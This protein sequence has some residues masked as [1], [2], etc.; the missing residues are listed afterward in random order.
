M[1]LSKTFSI[2]VTASFFLSQPVLAQVVISEIMYDLKGSD[3]LN[4]K[5]REW[6]E[7]ANV[8]GSAVAVATTTW[9]F[10]DSV[11]SANH[12]LSLYQGT[13]TILPGGFA[14][15]A[16]DPQTFLAD[17]PGFA[18]TIFGSSFSLVNSSATITLK[19]NA[20][21]VVDQVTYASTTGAAGDGNSLGL[22]GG[23]W[24][25]LAPTLG[26]LNQG[27]QGTVPEG[28]AGSS[29]ATTTADTTSSGADSPSG[30]TLSDDTGKTNWPVEPQIISRIVGPALGIAGADIIFKGE[31]VGLDKKPVKNVRYLW[32]FGDGATKEGESV[33]HA[34]NFPAEYVVILEV[35]S[36]NFEGASRYR[37]KIVP[38]DIVIADVVSGPDGKIELLNN[39]KQELDLSWW[40]VRSGNQ[41]FTL[42]KNTKILPA[43]R[44]PLSSL[45]MGFAV[46]DSDVALLYPNGSLA[47]QF[48]KNVPK[49][50]DVPTPPSVSSGPD[51]PEA[52]TVSPEPTE[53]AVSNMSGQEAAVA[54]AVPVQSEIEASDASSLN[55][56]AKPPS[57]LWLYGVGG[58]ILLGLVFSLFPKPAAIKSPA[59]EFTVLED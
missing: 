5:S 37:I 42:P 45:V 38:A 33:M 53:K 54:L 29:A 25:A 27:G 35:S 17:W 10:L 51:I 20:T 36:G 22:S 43:G 15:I 59:D 48:I 6:V 16:A 47:Y 44:L 26:A 50:A 19:S 32:N 11:G 57:S 28:Q 18:G 3:T 13:T 14:I 4:G 12:G 24:K 8:G 21:T 7:L 56:G 39:A 58:I 1:R 34:Y 30:T 46:A 2:I 55:D 9:K 40:R 31:A 41:F 49:Q 23:V 52:P